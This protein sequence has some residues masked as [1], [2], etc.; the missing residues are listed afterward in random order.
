MPVLKTLVEPEIKARFHRIAKTRRLSES[1]LLRAVVLAVTGQANGTEQPIALDAENADLDRMTIRMPR[2][3]MEAAK[4]RAK[5][6]GMAS[7]RWVVAMVQSNL[8]GQP[9]MNDAEVMELEATNRELAAIGR[10]LNQ[11]AKAINAGSYD[12]ERVQLDELAELRQ[13]ITENR[14]SIRALVRA[15]QNA[16]QSDT[17]ST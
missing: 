13:V 3:L 9:V 17:G 4:K 7:S 15:T 10:N 8:L 5:A 11:I 14:D 2:F 16:W 1:E 6:K 12:A